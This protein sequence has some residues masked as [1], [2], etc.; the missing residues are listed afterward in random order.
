MGPMQEIGTL[1]IQTLGS[2]FLIV[3]LLRFLLQ[4]ARADFYNPLSQFVVKAT[5]PLLI[6]LRRLIPGVMGIDVASLVLALLV[7]VVLIE[8][9]AL[10]LGV[11]FI[12]LLTVAVWG[13]IGVLSLLV[14]IYFWTLVVMVVAS[15]VAPHSRHPALLLVRQLVEPVMAPFRRILPDLGGI[16]ISPIFAFL[17]ISVVQILLRHL[18]AAV[19]LAGGAAQLV[20][21]V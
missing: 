17:A 6:P 16:D 15:W 5:N 4:L 20:V 7:Q 1:L 10:V 2:L 12:G 13:V 21:G 18:G 3:V 9:T 8:A 19:G 14:N 11:G